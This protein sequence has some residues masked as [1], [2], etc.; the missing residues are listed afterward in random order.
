MPRPVVAVVEDEPDILLL[1]DDL[2]QYAGYDTLLCMRGEDA[3]KTIRAAQP[4][5]I[6]LDLFL[7]HPKA[8]EQLLGLLDIDPQTRQIPVIIC[9]SYLHTL[10]HRA[11]LLQQRG[12]VL[13]PKPFDPD[14]LL[15]TLAALSTQARTA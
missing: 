11:E 4:D 9:S 2:L 15:A 1:I 6:L 8:G 12:H 13:M 7:E 10:E 14:T 5:I 3:H